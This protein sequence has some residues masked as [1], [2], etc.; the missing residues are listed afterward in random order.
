MGLY[1]WFMGIPWVYDKLRPFLLG[2]FD[3]SEPVGWLEVEAGQTVVDVGCGTGFALSYLKRQVEYHGFD[4][5]P[6][7]LLKLKDKYPQESITVHHQQ[8]SAQN[9]SELQPHKVILLGLLHHLNDAQVMDL[10]TTLA[11]GERLTRVVTEDPFYVRG[12]CANNLL[13]RLDRGHYVRSEKGYARLVE[14]CGW[15]VSQRFYCPAGNGLATYLCLGLEPG[16]K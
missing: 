3:F 6:R 2:G 1:Q 9:L 8:F 14:A 7:A 10:L 15:R 13:A 12:R 16:D 11:Q 5:D 4:T